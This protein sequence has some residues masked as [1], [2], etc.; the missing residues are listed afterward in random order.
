MYFL[1]IKLQH[2]SNCLG[3]LIKKAN[4]KSIVINNVHFKVKVKL[5]GDLKFVL[6]IYG[7]NAANSNYSCLWC[8]CDK[9]NFY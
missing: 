7:L 2:L 1:I 6:N 4:I 8:K 9:E 5:G 3:P